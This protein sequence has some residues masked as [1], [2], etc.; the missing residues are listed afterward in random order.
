MKASIGSLPSD[1]SLLKAST[2]DFPR[3]ARIVSEFLEIFTQWKNP[4]AERFS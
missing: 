4:K 3:S 2:P 1:V